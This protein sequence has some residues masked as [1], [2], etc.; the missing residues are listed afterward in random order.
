[1]TDTTDTIIN[2]DVTG[3]IDPRASHRAAGDAL[4]GH[5]RA[6]GELPAEL[7]GAAEDR[8]RQDADVVAEA[9]VRAERERIRRNLALPML[10]ALRLIPSGHIQQG[11]VVTDG[12]VVRDRLRAAY[13]GITADPASGE[14]ARPP[15]PLDL[16]EVAPWME[17]CG[18]CDAGL[19][20]ACTCPPGDA[21]VVIV[22]LVDEVVALRTELGR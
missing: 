15:L 1:M 17:L 21:R 13:M 19:P 7:D 16:V 5:L 12:D 22:R 11:C 9:A 8:L 18:S 3:H 4:I 14:Q 20:Q 6:M 2:G 10:Q